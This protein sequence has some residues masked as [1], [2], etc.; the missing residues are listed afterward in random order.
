MSEKMDYEITNTI[1]AEE[2]LEM[3]TY[4]LRNELYQK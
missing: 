4:E 3:R 2:Y 1:T